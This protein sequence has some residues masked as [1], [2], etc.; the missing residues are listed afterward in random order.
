MCN[1]AH[2]QGKEASQTGRC[3]R[4]L[5]AMLSAAEI[6]KIK[7]DIAWLQKCHD[8]SVD[9]G[10]RQLIEDWIADLKEKL[11]SDRSDA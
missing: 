9:S 6:A 5:P 4:T 11:E 1:I 7:A 2:L 3:Q 8:S 10:I